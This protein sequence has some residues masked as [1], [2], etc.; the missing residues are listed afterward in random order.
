MKRQVEMEQYF[1][2][3]DLAARCVEFAQK[4]LDWKLYEHIIEPSAGDGAFLRLLPED[5]RIG[6]DIEPGDPEIARADYLR[7]TP[8]LMCGP[9]LTIGNPPFGQRAA[10]AVAFLQKACQYSDAVAFILPRSFNKYTFQNR[11]DANFHLRG[12]LDCED[13]LTTDGDKRTVKTVFQVWEQSDVPRLP[14]VLAT[15]HADFEMKHCHLSRVTADGLAVLRS[16]YAFTIAQVGANFRPRDVDEVAK[17]SHW[18][19][20]PNVAG[21]RER[22]ERLDFSFLDG[23]NT[24]HKSLSKKDIIRAYDEQVENE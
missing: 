2:A 6:L 10:L 18:F 3:P 7:W 12:S 14:V 13:F 4:L 22:F 20:R 1:T 21:V 17:G 15:S 24:A 8:P 5:R 16:E 23:M 11:V 9:L 19:I